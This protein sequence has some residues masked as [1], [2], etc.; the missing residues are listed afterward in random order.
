MTRLAV[1]LATSLADCT[2]CLL[3]TGFVVLEDATRQALHREL[4]CFAITVAADKTW[5]QQLQFITYIFNKL[6]LYFTV[7]MKTMITESPTII[8]F[9]KYFVLSMLICFPKT[10]EKVY[11]RLANTN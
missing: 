6:K 1:E 2:K 3:A 10:R 11:Y 4:V 5:Q 8:A 9:Q 7:I